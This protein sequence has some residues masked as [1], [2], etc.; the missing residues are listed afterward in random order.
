VVNPKHAIWFRGLKYAKD[1]DGLL[2]ALLWR[3]VRFV[4]RIFHNWRWSW[5]KPAVQHLRDSTNLDDSFSL[6][7]L[8]DISGWLSSLPRLMLATCVRET[9]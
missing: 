9:T 6:T 4:L 1:I 8:T 5:K 2:Q 7:L 3:M